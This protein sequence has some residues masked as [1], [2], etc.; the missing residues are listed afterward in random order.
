MYKKTVHRT[1]GTTPFSKLFGKEAQYPIDLY[2]PKPPGDPRLELSEPAAELNEKLYEVH[3]HAQM[4]KEKEQRRQKDYNHRK[5]HGEPF[6]PGDLVWL[7]EPQKS[8]SRKFYLPWHGPYEVL[9]RTSEVNYRICKKSAPEKWQK[10][11]FNQL[12]PFVGDTPPRRSERQKKLV[13]SN[14]EVLTNF[15]EDT[16]S[17]ID[18]LLFN[19]FNPT[20]AESQAARNKPHVTFDDAPKVVERAS[21]EECPEPNPLCVH[22]PEGSIADQ[23]HNYEEISEG[24]DRSPKTE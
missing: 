12:K 5:V 8:K 4:T 3:G 15:L 9:S 13:A 1:T 6:E 20:T 17:E 21:D 18:G 16:E 11:H 10:V 2:Y 23:T 24:G 19:V 14:Y 7:L 22:I